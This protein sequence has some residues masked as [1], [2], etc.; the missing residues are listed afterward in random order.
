MLLK[1]CQRMDLEEHFLLDTLP[2]KAKLNAYGILNLDSSSGNGTY[3]VMW[4]KKCK[5]RFYFYSYGV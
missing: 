5:G 1:G 2:K 3:W 4:F